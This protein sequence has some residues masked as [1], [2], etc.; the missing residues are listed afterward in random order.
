MGNG[1]RPFLGRFRAAAEREG[2][3]RTGMGEEQVT[4]SSAT[5]GVWATG[6][7]LLLVSKVRRLELGWMGWNGR[8]GWGWRMIHWLL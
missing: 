3:G 6:S 7:D 2:R 8:I 5:T 1:Q 4:A